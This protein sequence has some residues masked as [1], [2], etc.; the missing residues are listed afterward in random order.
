MGRPIRSTTAAVSAAVGLAIGTAIWLA[1][2]NGLERYLVAANAFLTACLIALALTY[3]NARRKWSRLTGLDSSQTVRL[4]QHLAFISEGRTSLSYFSLQHERDPALYEERAKQTTGLLLFLADETRVLFEDYVKKPCAVSIKLLVPDAHMNPM[5]N[6][7]LRDSKSKLTR[8]DENYEFAA[9]SPFVDLVSGRIKVGY[10]LNNDLRAARD[11]GEYR[12]SRAD[13]DRDYNAT[14]IVPIKEPR[15]F[16]SQNIAGF[17][18]VDSL[19]GRFDEA[20]CVHMAQIVANCIFLSVV[21]LSLLGKNNQTSAGT[22]Q[23]AAHN[24]IRRSTKT[25]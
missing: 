11:R 20:A 23:N 19:T 7:Y 9:H 3:G 18:C 21:E 4:L 16:A 17:L 22:P 25:R 5:V 8:R 15:E 24:K 14:L 13:W 1:G 10:Y 6:T 12:N 2:G